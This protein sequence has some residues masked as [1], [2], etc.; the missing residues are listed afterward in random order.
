M[1]GFR[2]RNFLC[3]F[4]G[5][6]ELSETFNKV[7]FTLCLE[8]QDYCTYCTAIYGILPSDSGARHYFEF[9]IHHPRGLN[10]ILFPAITAKLAGDFHNN[11][12]SV[13]KRCQRFTYSFVS[14]ILCQCYLCRNSYTASRQSAANKKNPGKLLFGAVNLPCFTCLHGEV[15]PL[16]L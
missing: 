16:R 11:R 9:F 1:G 3:S 5:Q 13:E 10:I 12:R 4:Q 2:V 7:Y 6:T 15:A 14:F 8:S